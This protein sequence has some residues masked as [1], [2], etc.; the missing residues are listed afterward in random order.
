VALVPT[1]S[2]PFVPYRARAFCTQSQRQQVA[3]KLL[4]GYL[5]LLLKEL[6]VDAR[7]QEQVG[8]RGVVCICLPTRLYLWCLMLRCWVEQV[9]A[10]D[11]CH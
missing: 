8:G 9:W 11:W 7:Q 5:L 4:G 1:A 3:N 6:H 10:S 2:R